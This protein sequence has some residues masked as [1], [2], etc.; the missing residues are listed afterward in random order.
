MWSVD[1]FHEQFILVNQVNL[2]IRELRQERPEI[3]K[4]TQIRYVN[5]KLKGG[6]ADITVLLNAPEGLMTDEY[7]KSAEERIFDSILNTGV[8]SMKLTIR[9]VPVKIKEYK[10]IK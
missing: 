3:S 2:E 7:L 10:A 5:V 6:T 4:K 1:W 8:E 9:I